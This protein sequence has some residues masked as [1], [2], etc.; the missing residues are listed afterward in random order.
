MF[1]LARF[2]M[3]P[4]FSY[5]FISTVLHRASAL[6]CLV[7]FLSGLFFLKVPSTQA[8][9]G[10]NRQLSYQGKLLDSTGTAVADGTYNI[11][12]SLYSVLTGGSPIWTAA[13]LV[14]SPTALSVTV[15]GGLFTVALGDTSVAG[16][17]QNALTGIN[18][19]T[20][21]IYL[22]VTIGTDGEM[23]P[24]RRLTAIPQAFNSEQLQGMSASGTAFGGND[25][26]TLNQTTADS[27]TATRAVLALRTSGTSSANDLLLR[28]VNDADVTVL[29]IN[30]Q[31]SVTTTG[32]LNVTGTGTSTIVGLS[33][34]S[35]SLSTY[36]NVLGNV[37]LGD[38]SGDRVSINGQVLT[39][40]TPAGSTQSLG[41][42]GN[43]WQD[44]Y[45]TNL[46]AS[47]VSTISSL[48]VASTTATNLVAT[49]VTTTN[50]ELTGTLTAL[51]GNYTNLTATNA[52]TTRVTTTQLGVLGNAV[53]AGSATLGTSI[54]D[55]LTVNAG[56]ASDML[57]IDAARALGSVSA[58]W[59]YLYAAT[60]VASDVTTTR[61]L[62][63]NVTTTNLFATAVSTTDSIAL[64][65]TTTNFVTTGNVRLG[66]LDSPG[67]ITINGRI[68]SSLIAT[69]ALSDLG[70]SVTPWRVGYFGNVE[71]HQ[72]IDNTLRSDSSMQV[73]VTTTTGAAARGMFVSGKH[74]VTVKPLSG[75]ALVYDV[76]NPSA[77]TLTATLDTGTGSASDVGG[78]FISG[79]Y[80]YVTNFADS[81]LNVYDLQQLGA[82]AI[83]SLVL[84]I[85]PGHLF[86]SG[87]YAYIGGQ[88]S[89]QFDI[90][91][92]GNPARMKTVS[93]LAVAGPVGKIA[94]SGHYAYIAIPSLNDLSV[95][96]VR[97]PEQPI[98][99]AT[100]G[101]IT[102]AYSV[103]IQGKYLYVVGSGTVGYAFIYDITDPV[104][105][106]S[107]VVSQFAIAYTVADD[108]MFVSGRYLY[109]AEQS[110]GSLHAIDVSDPTTPVER[111]TV[112]LPG[113]FHQGLVVTGKHAY[114]LNTSASSLS[115]V[116]IL[117]TE[118]NGLVAATAEVGNLQ[119]LASGHIANQLS[120]GGGLNVGSGGIYTNGALAINATNTTSS[121]SGNVLIGTST[122]ELAMNSLF[123]L[124]GSDL[125]VGGSIG[126]ASSVYTNGAF[127]AS[128]T[129]FGVGIVNNQSGNLTLNAAGGFVL[130]S[131]DLGVSLGSEALRYNGI[132]GNSTTTN[133]TTTNLFATNATFTGVTTTNFYATNFNTA[134]LTV[135]G[136]TWTN[137]TGTNTTS[138]YLGVTNEISNLG[139]ST[140]VMQ[141]KSTVSLETAATDV[142]VSGRFAYV[143]EHYLK[144][145]DITDPSSP[146]T[147]ATLN[148]GGATSLTVAG[149]YA[150]VVNYNGAL[151]IVD[152]SNPSAPVT[153]KVISLSDSE[154]VEVQG[155]YAYVTDPSGAFYVIDVKDPANA[156]IVATLAMTAPVGVDVDGKYAYV[157]DATDSTLSK[158]DISNP[159]NPIVVATVTTNGS[160]QTVH[161]QGRH[162]Y[163]AT[164]GGVGH[165][166]QTIDISSPTS[167]WV[168]STYTPT[169]SFGANSLAVNGRYVYVVDLA[170]KFN[171]IDVLN[172]AAP[173]L[174]TSTTAGAGSTLAGVAISGRYA[175]I[176][177]GSSEMVIVDTMGIETTALS[178]QS[179]EVGNLQ[180]LT[181]GRI[182]HSLDVGNALSVGAGG[183]QSYGGITAYSSSTSGTAKFVNGA[184]TGYGTSWGAYINRLLVGNN[185]NATGTN[186]FYMNVSYDGAGKSGLCL[187][188]T[189]TASTCLLSAGSSI[190]ADGAVNASAFD[191]A[192]RYQLSGVATSSDVLVFDETA[193]MTLKVSPGVAYDARIAGVYSTKPGFLLGFGDGAPVALA[194]RVPTKVSAMNG[195]IAIGDLLTTSP[196]PGVAMKAT[197][198]GMTLGYALEPAAT[199]STI[200]VFIKV[201]Y[202]ALGL[203]NT[204]GT[205]AQMT[206]ELII[207]PTS[208]ASASQPTVDSWGMTFRGSAWDGSQAITSDF[209]LVNDVTS[210][211]TSVFS[212]LG[213]TGAPLV[214]IDQQ[215]TAQFAGDLIL[216]G[217]I[218]PATRNGAQTSTY[219]FVENGAGTSTYMAT[220]ADGW[221]A[222]DSYDFAE[223]YYSPDV[224]EPGDLVAISESGQIHVQRAW[225]AGQLLLGIVSTRPGFVTGKPSTST[226]PIALTGRV[227]TKVSTM[228]GAIQAGDPLAASSIPGIAVKAVGPG[229]IVGQAL[230][231]YDGQAIEKIEVY[232]NPSWWGGLPEDMPA[233]TALAPTSTAPD[234]QTQR[235]L[236]LML[237]GAKKVHV[238][239]ASLQ[240]YPNI[241]VT[242]YADVE[243]GWWI[244][245]VTD[246]GF[247]VLFKQAQT[248]DVSLSWNASAF[249][250]N[251]RVYQSDGTSA[252]VDPTTGTIVVQTITTSTR[253][254]PPEP[255]P[256]PVVEEPVV[257]VVPD[258]QI[259]EVEPV[260]VDEVSTTDV[261]AEPELPVEETVVLEETEPVVTSTESNLE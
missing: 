49:N 251:E 22:G 197:K 111:A 21:A 206:D 155:G 30:R 130:P 254:V 85:Q 58:P 67:Q 57:P 183:I 253:D 13:G 205:V 135:T 36:F 104:A 245:K 146:S 64:N 105:I 186:D 198:P 131:A 199:T 51:L 41:S 194:G 32:L 201:G 132:F 142:F 28:G 6:L 4:S 259:P 161:I 129:Y 231:N 190:Q 182:A 221:Q 241:Q 157:T 178:A 55:Q 84:G 73:L 151:N 43:R 14:S 220:N 139:R 240:G 173:V 52:T 216:S 9:L 222:N 17:S 78:V 91:D 29:S 98:D 50:L 24:R 7:L 106:S 68:A 110:A 213:T 158:I 258:A 101:G 214:R 224:L 86:V 1:P 189:N 42:L 70:E 202:S 168:V 211:S 162:A 144:I 119:V 54:A 244:D 232:V 120:V 66:T 250:E 150:Y 175:Y 20:D 252:N 260:I 108:G 171:M 118:T 103:S 122:R 34:A 59:Q 217:K 82:G 2:T 172:P 96:D 102:N 39:D 18:W 160:P 239:F 246:T 26:F 121:I 83:G 133:A 53:V 176:G 45:F 159:L 65:A 184:W 163:V 225:T 145:V 11:K 100:V 112:A 170:G 127:V 207:T 31:G 62:A 117:G 72:G 12:F 71:A 180:V 128:S 8:A 16:G 137:A 89:A 69:D 125:F 114:V 113:A 61:L 48:V 5:S 219:I 3:K 56:I 247:D 116:D 124:N 92:V 35:F 203:F 166:L 75:E 63:T 209:R 107:S 23:T 140:T 97:D 136:A 33:A 235:G 76:T 38:S 19:N 115:I 208:T 147:T 138:S 228:N 223:R 167:M 261:V 179:A 87:R 77:P 153:V 148:V 94:V 123:T 192:E 177:S 249:R 60:V 233:L 227:P 229:A 204:D 109:L 165:R 46:D 154:D 134:A 37:T 169:G 15:T 149:K 242:P 248:H 25:L 80:L 10:I 93:S 95:I 143:A 188:D 191:L 74:A 90:V 236:A 44:A 255:A 243:G 200:E 234:V 238:S 152:V 88:A 196:I 187:D 185:Q 230:E 215:G 40:I 164:I 181:D 81:T 226:Y 212:L 126:S 47:G 195:S 156:A 79:Q 193:S 174:V 256:T 257:N 27:A 218:Y 141:T 237:S 210:S 99:I